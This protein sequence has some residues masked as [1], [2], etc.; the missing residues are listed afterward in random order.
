MPTNVRRWFDLPRLLHQYTRRA[1]LILVNG[2]A[3]QPETWFANKTALSRQFDLK[4]PEIL[5]YDGD[6]L[7][8]WI[9]S[10]G[11]VTID[12]LA[13]R[14]SRFLDEFVQRFGELM[15]L[16]IVQLEGQA[17][18]QRGFL[19]ALAIQR[20]VNRAGWGE[21]LGSLR[22]NNGNRKDACFN[23]MC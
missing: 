6:S 22:V 9:D 20:I 7:H 14:L 15:V 1:P 13:G 23:L 4:V 16:A 19:H 21:I 17:Q 5:V 11:E 8:D 10:G 12:Y 3:E 2:L 18:D